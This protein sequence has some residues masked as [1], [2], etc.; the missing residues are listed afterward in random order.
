MAFRVV[1]LVGQADWNALERFLG[2]RQTNTTIV[3][4]IV[5]HLKA[6]GARSA[7]I[8][9]E[10]IDRDF[11]EAYSAYYAKTFRRHSK[12]C[13]RVLFFAS[14]VIFLNSITDVL[15]A[16]ITLSRQPYLGHVVLR[17]I[18][19]APLSRALLRTPPAPATFEGELLVRA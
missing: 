6:L 4:T 7:L 9:D 14:D 11:S 1:S 10:Y 19:G 17:P 13:T 16:A 2:E 18:A 15:Q 12:L 3:P 8:E 5:S